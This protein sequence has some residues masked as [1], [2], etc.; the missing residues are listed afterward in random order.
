MRIDFWKAAITGFAIFPAGF[1]VVT[2][3]HLLVDMPPD[4]PDEFHPGAVIASGVLF[5]TGFVASCI[6]QAFEQAVVKWGLWK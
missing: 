1:A 6:E 3:L 2:A 5:A 4:P